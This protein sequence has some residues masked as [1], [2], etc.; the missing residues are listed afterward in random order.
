DLLALPPDRRGHAQVYRYGEWYRRHLV[1]VH[2]VGEYQAPYRHGGVYIVLGGAGDIG[3][4]WSKHMI[5]RYGA[6]I[7]WVGRREK[8]AQIEA[9]LERLAQSGTAPL[10]FQADAGKL[11]ELQALR[12]SVL[13]QYGAIHGVIHAA[14]VFGNH[15][16]AD[17]TESQFK[18]ALYAKV[19]VSVR[20]AQVFGSDPLD[21]LLF[22]S[23]MISLIKNPKQA[24]YAAGCTFNDAFAHQLAQDMSCPVKVVNWGYWAAEKNAMMPEVR[25]LNELGV[26]L[27]E[28]GDGMRALDVLL[29]SSL[30]Q[31]G[32]MQL[33]KSFEVEGMNP[34]E[35]INLYPAPKA[36]DGPDTP[37]HYG[38]LG[39]L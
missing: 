16:L 17:M 37:P 14:M 39:G 23:S 30:P 24:H 25:Q 1:S 5:A 9:K 38:L 26:G 10:Y 28:P 11:D 31:L 27:I 18:A 33:T 19:N 32:V 4:A 3:A 15:D 20:L 6:K 13:D 21:F 12:S 29:G 36:S 35:T 22:F 7:I 2:P 34:F 8:D